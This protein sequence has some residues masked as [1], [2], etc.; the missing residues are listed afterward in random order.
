MLAIEITLS[1]WILLFI[2]IVTACAGA[3]FRYIQLRNYKERIS[4][5][6]HEML[7][8]HAQILELQSKI[9]SLTPISKSAPVVPMKENNTTEATTG[10]IPTIKKMG[11]SKK[12]QP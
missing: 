6:E 2:I 1:V 3:L 11:E 12:I 10:G 7:N 4:H 5:L 9:A 8:S